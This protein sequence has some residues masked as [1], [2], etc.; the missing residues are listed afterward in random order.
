MRKIKISAILSL[1]GVT[2]FLFYLNTDKIR[3]NKSGNDIY[4]IGDTTSVYFPLWKIN[5]RLSDYLGLLDSPIL[6]FRIKDTDCH[7]CIDKGLEA[8]H[9]SN[10]D[11]QKIKILGAYRSQ[12]SLERFLSIKNIEYESF[13]T[14]HDC[15]SDWKIEKSQMPYYFVIYPDMKVSN[16]FI[17][18]KNDILLTKQ[19]LNK[20]SDIEFNNN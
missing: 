6:C 13:I 17:P 5:D 19:Y 20:V 12:K 8:L 3:N 14:N 10:I 11:S 18:D 2:I 7:S 9:L 1:L 16:F 4:L 15:F